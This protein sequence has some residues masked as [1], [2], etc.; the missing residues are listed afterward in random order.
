MTSGLSSPEEGTVTP[1]L[2]K[3]PPLEQVDEGDEEFQKEIEFER[4]QNEPLESTGR[5]IALTSA[6]IIGLSMCL[7]ICLLFGVYV[8]NLVA[9]CVLAKSWL[10]LLL[11]IPM[12]L[13][14]CVSLFFFQVIF[15]NLFQMIG[16]IGGA[17]TNSKHYSCHKPSLAQAYRLG[18]RPPKITI[19]MPVYKEGMES[20]IMPTIRSLQAAVSFYESHGGSANILINDDG[21]RS[22]LPE[23]IVTQRREFYRDNN[24]GW[25][26]RPKHNGDEGFVRKGK[27]KKASNMNFALNLSQKVEAYLQEMVDTKIASEGTD[28]VS[29]SEEADMY[30]LALARVLDECSLAWADGDIRVG[31]IILIV[32]SDTRVASHL[33][34]SQ[35]G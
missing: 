5:P 28:V 14:L 21:I 33:M 18:F 22:G 1:Y 31:E 13:L 2:E 24:L 3:F 32:D 23:E 8:G 34:W 30:Q 16:P 4:P 25:V 29:E 11:I 26:A 7:A 35:E 6:F 15:N 27:F 12:P 10:Y 17:S 9:E 20:V 19:Q